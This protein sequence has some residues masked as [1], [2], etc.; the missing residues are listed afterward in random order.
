MKSKYT[1]KIISAYLFIMPFTAALAINRTLPLPLL[2]LVTSLFFFIFTANFKILKFKKS[3]LLILLILLLGL[4]PWVS[5]FTNTGSKNY[6]HAIAISVSIFLYFITVRSFLYSQKNFSWGMFAN[7]SRY[8]L[9]FLASA[10]IFEFIL[11]SFYGPFLSDIMPF[12][13]TDEELGRPHLLASYMRPR[14]FTS[15][16]GFT[17][18]FFEIC[19]PLAW[20]MDKKKI[21]HGFIWGIIFIAYLLLAS[22][23]SFFSLATSVLLTFILLKDKKKIL[24]LILGIAIICILYFS[25]EKIQYFFDDTLFR[26]YEAF[27]M[28]V[29]DLEKRVRPYIYYTSF[30]IIGE[31]PFG[32]GWGSLS[33]SYY[34]NTSIDNNIPFLIGGGAISLYLEIALASGWIGLGVFVFIIIRKIL[35]LYKLHYQ[36]KNCTPVLAVALSLT[37]ISLHHMFISL[38]H[39]P[40]LWFALAL[41]DYTI[42]YY[43]EHTAK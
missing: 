32:I 2:F 6:N 40:F 7:I 38:Y 1:N 21:K 35:Q 10:I 37:S 22:A 15:E 29:Y 20:L 9:L 4:I 39:L 25:V 11:A 23:A 19:L 42:F 14:A 33:Q 8:S 12:P 26:K 43:K 5:T 28:S 41:A 24:Y 34:D 18:L 3:D 31:Y 17:A 13:Y 27:N 30:T 16:A 36:Y